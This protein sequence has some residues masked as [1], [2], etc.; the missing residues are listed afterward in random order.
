MRPVPVGFVPLMPMLLT[1]KDG[2]GVPSDIDGA[3]RVIILSGAGDGQ[4][5]PQGAR[6]VD[7]VIWSVCAPI[8]RRC[9][10][11]ERIYLG[12][13]AYSQEGESSKGELHTAD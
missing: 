13:G 6:T 4:E 7:F 12:A 8:Y 2:Q 1:I 10:R 5:V 11:R 9:S 3:D